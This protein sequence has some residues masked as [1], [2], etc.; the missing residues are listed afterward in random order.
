MKGL[1]RAG[2]APRP[3]FIYG[4]IVFGRDLG[5]AW[6]LYKL[7]SRSYAGLSTGRKL[8]VMGQLEGLVHRVSADFQILRVG[9]RF[10]VPAYLASTWR[11]FDARH[12]SAE[13]VERRREAFGTLLKAHSYAL[14]ERE[15]V[16]PDVYLAV[17]L[18][19]ARPGLA[20]ALLG[21]GALAKA[22]QRFA[23]AVGIGDPRALRY[24]KLAEI[25]RAERRT[26]ELI[27][28]HLSAERALASEAVWLIRHAYL[29]GIADPDAEENFRPQ[30]LAISGPEGEE[31]GFEPVQWDLLRL[32]ADYRVRIA[33]RHL[34][35]ESER[36]VSHQALMVCG[37]LPE[38]RD[39]PGPEAELMFAP[40][41]LEFPVDACLHCEF[42][43]NREAQS[44]PASAPWT[45]I[46]CGA[47][48]RD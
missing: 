28:G 12:G 8:E 40:L 39:F 4:N 16:R 44:S 6:A 3:C 36:G 19:D 34:E 20:G 13:E 45:P 15:T 21:E 2:A 35:I 18:T 10:S 33:R 7:S 25:E 38:E 23:G 31:I 14:A 42:V 24:S 22:W 5:D 9:R 46:R 30:A 26:F 11:T 27:I 29:R 47:R 17:R 41:D 1:T 37:A 48:R 43:P 32:H